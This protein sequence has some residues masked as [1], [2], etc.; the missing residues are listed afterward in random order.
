M[1][2]P[3][4]IKSKFDLM[5]NMYKGKNIHDTVAELHKERVSPRHKRRWIGRRLSE[6][7]WSS[8]ICGLKICHLHY[9]E[10]LLLKLHHFCPK[11]SSSMDINNC[12]GQTIHCIFQRH[13]NFSIKMK[14]KKIFINEIVVKF[15][16]FLQCIWDANYLHLSNSKAITWS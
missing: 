10:F 8:K 2:V 4:K 1:C 7:Y 5:R 16:I 12:K 3:D 11:K 6:G 13:G 9:Q 14:R 15:G